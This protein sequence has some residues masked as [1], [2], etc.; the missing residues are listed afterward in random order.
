VALI[1]KPISVLSNT[2]APQPQQRFQIASDEKLI[3]DVSRFHRFWTNSLIVVF[4]HGLLLF[5]FQHNQRISPLQNQGSHSIL[6][7]RFIDSP[8]VEKATLSPYIESSS[9]AVS[10]KQTELSKKNRLLQFQNE[11]YTRQVSSS[12]LEVLSRDGVGL[13]L[14]E[15]KYLT[16][17]MLDTTAHPIED[18]GLILAK[19]FPVLSG[20][21]IME[22]WIDESGKVVKV[23]LIQ[24]RTISQDYDA[25]HPLL[26]TTFEPAMKDG[27]AVASRKLIEINT[28][29]LSTY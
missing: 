14:R 20:L 21:I 26:E 5:S 13:L 7:S 11:R 2:P 23:D 28:D 4:L 29:I 19:I 27:S 22:L 25:L 17:N 16:S 15:D 18:M 24:G 8:L 3:L 6:Y 1:A 9:Q 12:S 10:L